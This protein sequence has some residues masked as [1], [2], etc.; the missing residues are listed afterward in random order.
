MNIQLTQRKVL[1]A[2]ATGLVGGLILK[3]LL[4]DSSVVEVHT[5]SRRPLKVCHPK[6]QVHIVNFT[7]LPDL[8]PV[9][10]VY[11]ALGTTIRV[12]GSKAA[13]RAV[14]YDANLAV[15]Q[16]A[17]ASGARRVGLVSAGASSAHSRM[18]YNRVKGE[19][20]DTLKALPFIALVIA[21]PSM[22]L[23]YR[24]GLDQP[25]RYGELI[26]IPLFKLLSP[27]LPGA[28]KPVHAKAV[29]QALVRTVPTAEGLVVYPSDALA[30]LGADRC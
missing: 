27:I 8:P 4:E 21:Q 11:L 7:Q 2:G 22:L 12:A 10:E 25:T 20:E 6:L 23:D 9:D 5:L 1:L 17:F 28:Y 15:A 14:D 29:A 30:R 18:F 24:K 26:G 19:L 13:F 3:A 16:S